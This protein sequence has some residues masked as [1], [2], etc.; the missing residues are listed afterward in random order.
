[1]SILKRFISAVLSL[2]IVLSP[3]AAPSAS[4]ESLSH[5]SA[6]RE[7]DNR[8]EDMDESDWFFEHVAI[9]YNLGLMNG[10]SE[11]AFSPAREVTFAEALALISH[12]HKIFYADE[13]AFG[14]S[15]PW[16]EVYAGY[17]REKGFHPGS[18]VIYNKTASRGDIAV[19]LTD[20]LPPLAFTPINSI[21]D[22][23][24]P[25]AGMSNPRSGAIY[26]LYRAGIFSGVD[27]SGAFHPDLGISRAELSA[28]MTKIA[29]P[30]SRT[31]K[32]MANP[33]ARILSSVE[34]AELCS[35]AVFMIELFN[36]E[37]DG[38]YMEFFHDDAEEEWDDEDDNTENGYPDEDEE[39]NEV[40]FGGASGFFI[41]SDG[42]AITNYH[43]IEHADRAVAIT[44]DG[45]RH[46]IEGIYSVD[47]GADLAIIKVKGED[48]P[49]L[50][51]GDSG[52][53]R[54]GEKIYLIGS[55]LGLSNTFT[56][57]VIAN[58]NR[59]IFE[60]GIPHIQTSIMAT[61]GSSGGAV[62]NSRG[63]VIGV[64][65]ASHEYLDI[66]FA[67][68]IHLT[69]GLERIMYRPFGRIRPLILYPG[70]LQA[71]DFWA[72]TGV[73]HSEIEVSACGS[74]SAVYG[75]AEFNSPDAFDFKI[76]SYIDSLLDN[77]MVKRD[78]GENHFLFTGEAETLELHITSEFVKV[79]TTVQPVFYEEFP[80]VLDLG[81]FLGL[82]G[83]D[84]TVLWDDWDVFDDDC[85]EEE[86]CPCCFDYET[87]SLYKCYDYEEQGLYTFRL[88][89]NA[90]R[91]YYIPALR[92]A[93]FELTDLYVLI[94]WSYG[95]AEY[96]LESEDG[97]IIEI[98]IYDSFFQC[99]D[100]YI[101]TLSDIKTEEE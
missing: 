42:V 54:Q 93:G 75:I 15:D 46:E 27:A 59:D 22:G 44:V 81:W 96:S 24:I 43:V 55:P 70:C 53:I 79:K 89:N 9:A 17:A 38:F 4:G 18:D 71:L 52:T 85:E 88:L 10:T 80:H 30:S 41:T 40:P 91:E 61:Y 6:H 95:K 94:L 14:Q 83:F 99:I 49:T 19:I 48:F 37:F 69:A 33:G 68:P 25:D 47:P 92:A 72:F 12:L 28:I 101:Y 84:N 62:I 67:V 64:M 13:T 60:D 51:L 57:G 21:D 31:L 39:Y 32:N 8:F 77:E 56:E 16:Y 82:S 3:I 74:L 36:D 11:T 1:V 100:I 73:K 65:T 87:N 7:Y 66:N 90:I 98:D 97:I 78:I 5:F 86:D 23:S 58:V 63:Q 50:E 34:I 35:P 26:T 76:Q 29:I 45:M 20:A 2:A